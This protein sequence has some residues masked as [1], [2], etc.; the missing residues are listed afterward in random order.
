[1]LQEV[2]RNMK[3]TLEK[4]QLPRR[5]GLEKDTNKLMMNGMSTAKDVDKNVRL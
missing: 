3:K 4:P 5:P 2:N 1:M